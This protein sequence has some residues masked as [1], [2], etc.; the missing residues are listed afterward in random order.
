MAGVTAKLVAIGP[1]NGTVGEAVTFLTAVKMRR[2]VGITPA[3]R[4]PFRNCPSDYD[5]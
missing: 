4:R 1:E 2:A 5:A 3:A